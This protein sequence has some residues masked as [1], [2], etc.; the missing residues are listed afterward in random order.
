M[1]S[2]L[3]KTEIIMMMWLVVF[4]QVTML[5][6]RMTVIVARAAAMIVGDRFEAD[7]VE[8]DDEAEM[9]LARTMERN[10]NLLCF[11]IAAADGNTHTY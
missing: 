5:V 7:D 6:I 3:M 9:A 4:M 10:M 8:A 1:L 11:V 2:V